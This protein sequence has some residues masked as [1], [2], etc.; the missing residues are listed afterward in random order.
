MEDPLMTHSLAHQRLELAKTTEEELPMANA[1]GLTY[2]LRA[3]CGYIGLDAHH[4]SDSGPHTPWKGHKSLS[5]HVT[6]DVRDTTTTKPRVE[7]PHSP[8]QPVKTGQ[9]RKSYDT[10]VSSQCPKE[11]CR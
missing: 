9:R 5:F 8:L 7:S 11:V 3:M 6:T 2:R 1:H 10:L 4:E